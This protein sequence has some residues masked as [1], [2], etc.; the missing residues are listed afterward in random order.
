MLQKWKQYLMHLWKCFSRIDSRSRFC[1]YIVESK[2]ISFNSCSFSLYIFLSHC[3]SLIQDEKRRELELEW[4]GQKYLLHFFDH[5]EAENNQKFVIWALTAGILIRA[6]SLVYQR[7]PAFEER[8]PFFWS[9]NR[10]GL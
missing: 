10:S 5:E 6:A 8:R 4:M 7:P 2:I 1:I 3:C 9:R